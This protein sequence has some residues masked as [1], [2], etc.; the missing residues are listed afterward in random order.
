M[1]RGVLILLVAIQ[2]GLL[3]TLFVLLG[4]NHLTRTVLARRRRRY[5]ERL[6]LA[7]LRWERGQIG[8]ERLEIALDGCPPGALYE[9]L[10]RHFD[11]LDAGPARAL[12]D[13]L[14]ASD[15][16]PKA[17]SLARS[18]FW[19]RRQ[20]GSEL[21]GYMGRGE[22]ADL[23]SDLLADRHPAVA[24]AA[25]LAARRLRLPELL[26]PLLDQLE[27]EGPPG[28]RRFLVDV[29]L[30]YGPRLVR[31]LIDR[32]EEG[33]PPEAQ[34]ARLELAGR[35][36]HPDLA[37]PVLRRAREGTLEVRINAARALASFPVDEALE[38]LRS[39]LRDPAW[40]VRVQAA[41]A[42]GRLGEEAAVPDL[43][44]ALGDP[45]W[46]VR[47]RAALALRRIG[48]DGVS[49]L[50]AFRD[51][52]GEEEDRYAAEMATYVL[53]LDPEALQEHSR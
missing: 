28:H 22:D 17:R 9:V 30:G 27:E 34:V 49:V 33:G 14:R 12:V 13:R 18:P 46:W 31:A 48:E 23:I 37:D 39:A 29:L 7:L 44:R 40:E 2:G 24:S 19:W 50:E 36:G 53:S 25:L 43:R 21:L 42:F 26:E 6:S 35:L 8:P 38:P 20:R 51:G 5:A 16:L 47:L 1:S 41:A 32:L 45:S 11:Q 15:R 3:V 4:W 10:E 52:S